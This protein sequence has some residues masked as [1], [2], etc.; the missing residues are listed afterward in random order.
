M[1]RVLRNIVFGIIDKEALEKYV[2][3][4]MIGDSSE[5]IDVISLLRE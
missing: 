2:P 1:K 5:E 3:L 4:S